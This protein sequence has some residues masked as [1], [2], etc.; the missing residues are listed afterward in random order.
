MQN[1]VCLIVPRML[2]IVKIIILKGAQR[3]SV[4]NMPARVHESLIITKLWL[5]KMWILLLD[6]FLTLKQ[7][8]K[9]ETCGTLKISQKFWKISG[10]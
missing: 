10:G 1:K 9:S 8:R 4:K 6:C 7:Y 5:F 2:Q 3:T